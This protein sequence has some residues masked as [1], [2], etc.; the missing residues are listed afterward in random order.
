M[1]TDFTAKAGSG[2]FMYSLQREKVAAN[3]AEGAHADK[4]AEQG[5]TDQ[6]ASAQESEGNEKPKLESKARPQQC[7]AGL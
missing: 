6:A 2:Q 7:V 4:E 5:G 1:P 3:G